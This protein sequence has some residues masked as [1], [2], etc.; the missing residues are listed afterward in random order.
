[1]RISRLE[2]KMETLLSAMQSLIGS[3]V[4]A[5][6]FVNVFQPLDG[7]GISSSASYSDNTLV[8]PTSTNLGF[9]RDS[10]FTTDSIATVS[11]NP[12]T[13]SLSQLYPLSPR[14]PSLNQAGERVNFFRFRMLP[15]FPFI[16]PYPRYDKLVSAPK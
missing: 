1:M 3:R 15:I 5:E 9:S 4:A 10:T 14:A 6:P 7:H 13:L 11:S 2:D 8:N 16:R 12:N